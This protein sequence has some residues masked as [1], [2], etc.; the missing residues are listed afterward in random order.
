VCFP[1]IEYYQGKLHH[2]RYQPAGVKQRWRT[3]W[4]DPSVVDA[5]AW[6]ESRLGPLAGFELVEICFVLKVED[7]SLGGLDFATLA[8]FQQAKKPD[9]KS[10]F[11]PIV[12][13]ERPPLVHARGRGGVPR[14]GGG[15]GPLEAPASHRGALGGMSQKRSYLGV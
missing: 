6:L 4:A 14:A 2:L 15:R 13:E 7:F 11:L 5:R 3:A 12:A 8:V 1:L 9:T 10:L